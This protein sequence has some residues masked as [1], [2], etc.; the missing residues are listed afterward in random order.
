MSKT[1][2]VGLAGL[3]KE[4]PIQRQISWDLVCGGGNLNEAFL[5]DSQVSSL[6]D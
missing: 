5:D 1:R 6:G 2:L 3:G 4:A